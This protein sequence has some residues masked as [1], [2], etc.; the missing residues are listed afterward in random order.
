MSK[1]YQKSAFCFFLMALLFFFNS[2][3]NANSYINK[4]KVQAKRN[5][6]YKNSTWLA[7]G[8]YRENSFFRGYTSEVDNPRFF[9]L[10]MAQVILKLS[11]FLP[12]MGCS[13]LR[14]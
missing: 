7:L 5:K 13:A 1:H 2:E 11:Y 10:L 8:Y 6:L 4:L 9:F 12:S 3:A 14:A